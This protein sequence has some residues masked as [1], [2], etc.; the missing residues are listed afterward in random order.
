M[1]RKMLITPESHSL[2]PMPALSHRCSQKPESQEGITAV[3]SNVVDAVAMQ[4]DPSL[5]PEPLLRR[6]DPPPFLRPP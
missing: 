5:P 4:T 2:L 3:Y 6:G 1:P